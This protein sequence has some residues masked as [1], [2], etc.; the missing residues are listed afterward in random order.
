MLCLIAFF[1]F[2]LITIVKPRVVAVNE[3]TPF[4]GVFDKM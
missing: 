3:V 1:T 2:F 4:E